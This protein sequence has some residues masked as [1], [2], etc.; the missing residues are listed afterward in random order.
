MHSKKLTKSLTVVSLFLCGL[1]V[2]AA[3]PADA[4]SRKTITTTTIDGVNVLVFPP[5]RESVI[6]AGVLVAYAGGLIPEGWA[7]C[8]GSYVKLDASSK[9]LAQA[10]STDFGGDGVKYFRIPDLRGRVAVGLT[11]MGTQPPSGTISAVWARTRG[12]NGYGGDATHTLTVD[13]MPRH[14]H[15]GSDI[16]GGNHSHRIS[17]TGEINHG[18]PGPEFTN[19]PFGPG[20]HTTGIDG[21]DPRDGE[22]QH[23]LTI[24][25]QGNSK[26]VSLVQPSIAL[27]YL[28]KY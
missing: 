26:E 18:R 19:N 15:S 16:K 24:V 1:L 20:E 11:N 8:D 17:G 22:H 2:L 28:I 4:P 5:V 14:D 9:R 3:G 23:V 25:S 27:N 12:Q 6:P 21:K 10:L 7:L 13:E